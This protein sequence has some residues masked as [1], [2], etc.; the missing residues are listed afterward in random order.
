MANSGPVWSIDR[1]A[2]NT[3]LAALNVSDPAEVVEQVAE[4]FARHRECA[5]AWAAER[6]QASAIRKLESASQELFDRHSAEWTDGFRAAE[7][8]IVAAS[9][10]DLLETN[11]GKAQSTGQILRKLVSSARYASIQAQA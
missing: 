6:V 3:L 8:Q 5:H 9:P 10:R 7:A 2:A 4:M 1:L 11:V